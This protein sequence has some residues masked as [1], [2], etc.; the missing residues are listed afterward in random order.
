MGNTSVKT[1]WSPKF[2]RL[3]CGISACRNSLYELVCNSMRFGGAMISL[4]FPK[5]ILSVD[6]DGIWTFFHGP[7]KS[8]FVNYTKR[9]KA[10]PPAFTRRLAINRT[11]QSCR[12]GFSVSNLKALFFCQELNPGTA[13]TGA[14]PKRAYLFTL[15]RPWRQLLRASSWRRLHPP[16]ELL[17]TRSWERPQPGPWLQPDRDRL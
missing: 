6:R 17:P 5:L 16:W 1:A 13:P 2:R 4:I 3:P 11:T 15:I 10:S 14:V 9:Q 7:A 8:R 12:T